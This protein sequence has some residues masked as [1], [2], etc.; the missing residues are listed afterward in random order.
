[1]TASICTF[2]RQV[3]SELVRRSLAPRAT[4]FLLALACIDIFY[5]AHSNT[6]SP[7]QLSLKQSQE[8]LPKLPAS[9]EEV[10]P[11]VH[12]YFALSRLQSVVQEVAAAL[13]VPYV[14]GGNKLG[15]ETTCQECTECII[16]KKLGP[17]SRTANCRACSSCGID[18]SHLVQ[19]VFSAAGLEMPYAASNLMAKADPA[20]LLRHYNLV[21]IGKDFERARPGDIIVYRRHVGI[22]MANHGD[23]RGDLVH[24]SRFARDGREKVGGIRYDINKNIVRPRGGMVRIL[25]HRL[26]MGPNEPLSVRP[27]KN[28]VLLARSGE[29]FEIIR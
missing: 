16:K 9:P 19:Q 10:P 5:T 1:M 8:L 11:V 28:S 14:W 26:L 7:E 15:N 2:G 27:H 21:D 29:N 20:T 24:A 12:R 23:N 13:H 17:K 4:I 3:S 25:R 18:C 6:F 22:L